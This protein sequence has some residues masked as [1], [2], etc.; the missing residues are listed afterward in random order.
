MSAPLPWHVP[1]TYLAKKSLATKNPST[2]LCTH[3]NH[4]HTLGK[5]P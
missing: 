5:S 2:V 4:S 1:L 3:A